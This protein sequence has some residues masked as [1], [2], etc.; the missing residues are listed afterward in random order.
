MAN[1]TMELRRLRET[2][3]ALPEQSLL[4]WL[5]PLAWDFATYTLT[6]CPNVP[7]S[8]WLC[9]VHKE[10][11]ATVLSAAITLVSYPCGLQPLSVEAC[12]LQSPVRSV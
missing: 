5:K 11:E 4:L 10:M 2:A 8:L 3:S 12:C 1:P 9:P 7:K 6:L